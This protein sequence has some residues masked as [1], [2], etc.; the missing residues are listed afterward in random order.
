MT[1][2]AAALLAI[3]FGLAACGEKAR[4]LPPIGGSEADVDAA[5]D[6]GL[7]PDRPALEEVP[8]E[9]RI[10]AIE[11]A[12]NA[13][14]PVANQCWAAS[15]A[16]DFHLAGD[17]RAWITIGPKSG[18]GATVEITE[19]TTDDDQITQCLSVVL[20]AYAWAPPLAGQSIELPFHFTAPTMQN[21][22][23]RQFVPHKAQASIDVAVLLDE[24]NTGNPAL[25]MA[26]VTAS[27]GTIGPRITDRLEIWQ[28]SASSAAHVTVA[29][30]K[31]LSAG[32]N[33]VVIVPKGTRLTIAP[34]PNFSARV[35]FIPGGREGTL[36]AGAVP[37]ASATLG[38]LKKGEPQVSLVKA[39]AAKMYP[40]PGRTATI[41]VEPPAAKGAVSVGLLTLDNGIAVPPHVHAKETE[42]LYLIGGSG[43]MTIGGIAVP[44]TAT[45]VV[46]IPAGVEHSFK[47]TENVSALQFYTPAGPE[48]RFKKPPPTPPK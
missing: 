36:R 6:E 35:L 17:V 28:M 11:V 12:M 32:K 20:G 10:A 34:A 16:D 1:R 18:A 8:E 13:L 26:E 21:V 2:R 43:T 31:T 41:L 40:A 22:V 29:G 48:Q 4:P 33:D 23:D 37:G 45:S 44:V 5:P 30:G 7:T 25:S 27:A 15:A 14:A 47:P 38:P 9:E 19:N 42:A 3:P 46:Q 24:T 39:D